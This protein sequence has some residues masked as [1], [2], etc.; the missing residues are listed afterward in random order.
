MVVTRDILA[1][2]G[3]VLVDMHGQHEHQSLIKRERHFSLL[4]DFAGLGAETALMRQAFNDM[5]RRISALEELAAREA[6]RGQQI[7]ELQ[8]ELDLLDR[9][10]LKR[11]EEEELQSFIEV[12]RYG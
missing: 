10:N 7:A 9:A 2:I 5:K 12:K 4:D 11:G 6:S 3:D 1:R 8:E